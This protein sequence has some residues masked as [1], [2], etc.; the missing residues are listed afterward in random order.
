MIVVFVIY[1][2]NDIE[3]GWS[4]LGNGFKVLSLSFVFSD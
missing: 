3:L 1:Q 4:K 2:Y